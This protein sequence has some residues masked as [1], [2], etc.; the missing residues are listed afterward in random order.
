[1]YTANQITGPYSVAATWKIP[2]TYSQPPKIFAYA[3]KVLV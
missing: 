2:P 3:P 1:M